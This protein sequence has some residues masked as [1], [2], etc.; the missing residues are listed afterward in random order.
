MKRLK[1]F[2]DYKE[3]VKTIILAVLAAICV[4]EALFWKGSFRHTDTITNLTFTL[5][6]MVAICKII[7]MTWL[8]RKKHLPLI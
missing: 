2:F 5:L 7:I 3:N 8:I 6:L 1:K 4:I